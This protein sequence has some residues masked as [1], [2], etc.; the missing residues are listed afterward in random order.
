MWNGQLGQ[1]HKYNLTTST[2]SKETKG[3]LLK[4]NPA[5][6]AICLAAKKILIG[7]KNGEIL[8]IDKDGVM[9]VLV[10]VK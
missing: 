6:R 5:I 7:T 3:I 4:D 10:Q 8:D 1:V 9:G 2:L